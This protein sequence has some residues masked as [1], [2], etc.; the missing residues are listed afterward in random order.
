MKKILLLLIV[1]AS[2]VSA[3][4]LTSS[5]IRGTKTYCYYSDGDVIV[6]DGMGVCDATN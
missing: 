6:I 4:V 5:E 2:I 3:G 1:V